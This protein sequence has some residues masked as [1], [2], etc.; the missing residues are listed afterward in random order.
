[1]TDSG[2]RTPNSPQNEGF[3][4]KSLLR[5]YISLSGL[6]L[7]AIALAN[8][9]VLFLIDVTA[10]EP[11][12]YTGLL[13]YMVLPAFLVLGLVAHRLWH[14]GASAIAASGPPPARLC[15]STSI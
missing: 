10:A 12:P 2:P 9:L 5:N 14:C 15:R 6:A 13:A 8:I 3:S 11:N 7:A 1:M 4:Y